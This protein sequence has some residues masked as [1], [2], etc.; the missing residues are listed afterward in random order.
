MQISFLQPAFQLPAVFQRVMVC[1]SRPAVPADIL[2]VIGMGAKFLQGGETGG[3]FLIR[4]ISRFG[5]GPEPLRQLQ[6]FA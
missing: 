5:T 1:I 6:L 4:V 3:F 2:L